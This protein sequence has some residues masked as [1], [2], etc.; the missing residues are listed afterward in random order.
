MQKARTL[1]FGLLC[2]L[3]SACGPRDAHAVARTADE[4]GGFG[5]YTWLADHDPSALVVDGLDPELAQ[6]AAPDARTVEVAT[7]AADGCR[8]ARD[9][10]AL[11]AV[12]AAKH[13]AQRDQAED[14]GFALFHDDLTLVV[15]PR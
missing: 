12:R 15:A 5:V 13:T 2:F 4:A 3:L 6:A 8:L 7:N 9:R 10:H 11:F 1:R 14:C